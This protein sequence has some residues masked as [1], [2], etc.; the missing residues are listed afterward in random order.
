MRQL[1]SIAVGT[2]LA[3][4]VAGGLLAPSLHRVQHAMEQTAAASEEPCHSS[5][6]HD[7]EVPLWT[8]PGTGLR[9]P[10]CDLCATRLLVV[11]ADPDPV[12][13]TRS[14]TS[15]WGTVLVHLTSAAVA[16][17][18]FIRGPPMRA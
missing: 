16:A 12:E 4:F 11:P 3:T 7:S 14:F 2:L 8:H 17:A 10:D 1:R 18:P 13:A 9:G 6:V 5:D 15:N